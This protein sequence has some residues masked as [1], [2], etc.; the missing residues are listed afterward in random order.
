MVLYFGFETE[1]Q[2]HDRK[3]RLRLAAHGVD[4]AKAVIGGDLAEHI[5]IVDHASE[6][7]H[8]V[9]HDL[10]RRHGGG[11]GVVRRVQAK[12]DVRPRHGMQLREGLRQHR[13]ADLGAAATAAH[14]ALRQFADRCRVGHGRCES[15]RFRRGHRRQIA[16][17]PHEAAVD[18]VL[19]APHQM[20]VQ[21]PV[22][23]R[24]D[25]VFVARADQ[26]EERPLR[27]ER[28]QSAPLQRSPQVFTKRRALA[29]RDHT[30][31]RPRM[32]QHR[33]D[34]AGGEDVGMRQRLQRV[35][36]GNEPFRIHAQSGCGDPW[37]RTRGGRPYNF[38]QRIVRALCGR[39][40][41]RRHLDHRAAGNHV[42]AAFAQH[43]LEDVASARVVAGKDVVGG[44]EKQVADVVVVA[45]FLP[46]ALAQAVL[47]GEQYLD[48]AGAGTDNADR[49]IALV[50]QDAVQHLLPSRD[51]AVDR[52]HRHN[53]SVRSRH[54]GGP[55]RRTD[56]ERQQVI[57]NWWVRS[58]VN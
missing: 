53:I 52:L 30:R 21:R 33:G 10:S 35:T 19:P 55:R 31:F 48:A 6:V 23:A 25:G 32:A 41:T 51:E 46:Q 24:G 36:H 37:R 34:I 47:R 7:I 57:T 13:A 56:V 16:V 20:S 22:V 8:C 42:H 54:V 11:G 40:A 14:G 58:A 17:A 12:H 27:P 29:H 9:Q 38:V 50:C 15:R 44:T 1:R 26:A 45:A 49:E 43:A 18:A 39:Q 4:V 3:R 2:R 5:R 28:H